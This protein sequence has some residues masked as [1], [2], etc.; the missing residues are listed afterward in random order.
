M[1]DQ[2]S[3]EALNHVREVFEELSFPSADRL[4]RALKQRG[5]PAQAKDV[6]ALVQEESSRQV[7]APAPLLK[8]KIAAK[9]LHELWFADLI[10]FTQTPTKS[11]KYILVVQDVFSRMIWTEPHTQQDA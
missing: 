5:I 1:E 4:L 8:G 10:D 11:A 6:K 7:Q 3:R 2:R 9:H